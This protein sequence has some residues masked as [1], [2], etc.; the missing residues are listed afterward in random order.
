M[1]NVRIKPMTQLSSTL[2]EFPYRL[3]DGCQRFQVQ[4]EL[5]QG[6]DFC[7]RTVLQRLCQAHLI[8][9]TIPLCF[10][11]APFGSTRNPLIFLGR[12]A[13]TGGFHVGLALMTGGGAGGAGGI[14]GASTR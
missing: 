10:L 14:G 11:I 8:P 6:A 9:L 1:V 13:H 4:H 2:P 7:R 5:G 12:H 3:K